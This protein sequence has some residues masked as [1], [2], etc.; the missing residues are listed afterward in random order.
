MRMILVGKTAATLIVWA[1][2]ASTLLPAYKP[3]TPPHEPTAV[4]VTP[5]LWGPPKPTKKTPEQY[6]N[7][8][9]TDPP[10]KPKPEI[11]EITAYTANYEST[12]KH[13]WDDGYGITSS[14]KHV[15][16][17]HTL[18]CPPDL[19]TGTRIYIPFFENTFVC[20]DTGSAI[21]AGHLDVYMTTVDDALEFGRRK[22]PVKFVTVG[23]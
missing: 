12:G 20:E 5:S 23:E 21:T 10:I 7:P 3:T 22:L 13:P 11:Y 15:Q 19:S 8:Y 16:P 17:N 14:G 2:L 9:Q 6:Y 1:L 4:Y 18:A